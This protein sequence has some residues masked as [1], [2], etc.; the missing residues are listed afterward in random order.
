MKAKKKLKKM[1]AKFFNRL[2]CRKAKR[3]QVDKRQKVLFKV[4]K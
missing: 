1:R 4:A 2:F 3:P